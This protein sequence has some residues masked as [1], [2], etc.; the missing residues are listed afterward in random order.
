[1]CIKETKTKAVTEAKYFS[2]WGNNR[3]GWVHNEGEN[4]C[5][6]L[7]SMWNEEAFCYSSHMM[8]KGF[9]AIFGVHIKS[10]VSCV[11]VNVYAAC[12]LNDKKILWEELS[13]VKLAS[14]EKVWCFCGDFNAVRCRSKRKGI[15]VGFDHSSEIVGFNSFI[16]T[17]LL[18]DLPIVGKNYT[19]FKAN[20]SAKSRI[21]RVLVSEEWL[22]KWPMS[23]QYVKQREVS[24]HC[25]IVVKSVE[26][27]WGPKPFRSIDAWF[28]ERGFREMVKGKWL[29]YPTEGNALVTFKEKLKRLKGDFKIWNRDV[30]GNIQTQKRIILPEIEDL[31]CKDCLDDLREDDRLKRVELVSR[32]KEMDKKMESLLS[33]KARASWFK[34]GDSCTRFYHSSLRW[35]RFRNDVK[36]EEV[37]GLWS[38]E[39][40]TV[41]SEAKKL[42]ENRFKATKDLGV[43]LDNVEF[44]ILSYE[45]NLGLIKAF[46]EEE[47]RDAVWLCDGSKS[48]GP[49][50]FN[51]NFVKESWEVFK[52]VI[53]EVMVIF[54]KS[55]CIPKGCNASFVALIPKVR[56]PVKLEQYRPISLVGVMYK[57]ISKVLAERMKK[58][59]P[60]IIDECQSAFL[61]DRGILDSVLT[62]NEV[63]EDLR[64]RRVSGLCLKVDFKKAYDSVRWDYLYDM[65]HRM[66]FHSKWIMWIKGCLASATVSVLVN[67]CPTEEFHPLRGLRQGD[68]LAPFLFL[69]AAEGLAGL[70]RQAVK[71]NLYSGLNI[72]SKEVELCIIQFADDTL[73]LCQDA[74]SNVFTLKALLRGFEVASGL[75]INFR[76]SKLAGINVRESNMDCYTKTLNCSQMEVPFIYLG[77]EVGGNPRRKKFWEPVLNKLKSRLSVWKGRFLSMAGRLCLIKS[78][79]SAIPL[80]YLS[81]FKAPEVVCKSIIRIQRRFMWGWGKENR[82]VSWISWKWR[83]ISNDKGR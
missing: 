21:N 24:D 48:P 58:V 45:D 69:V 50:G 74:Y 52:E 7:L 18:M 70:V 53:V 9:I 80:F 34:N 30:F 10:N 4:G 25:A 60:A 5:G 67:G 19:W 11:M 47:I 65:L 49:D 55:G 77:L 39:P 68:P 37:G 13:K 28:S 38:E 12:T 42:F 66:R 61:K 26:K 46:S 29:S 32:L 27:D 57:I 15:R 81:L 73:F 75:K 14:Q 64:R 8:G 23:K 40:S 83:S 31:D 82:P 51:L 2:V 16:D 71:V 17:N 56:D 6:S 78:V 41:R 72:G 35:R 36:G 20:G 22:V 79:L 43:R 44:K 62:A 54:H 63:L 1:M 3:V 59:L 33:Q 76:K